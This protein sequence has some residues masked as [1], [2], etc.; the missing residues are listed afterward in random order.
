M[1]IIFRNFSA[2]LFALAA[3][4]F[5]FGYS[6]S[7]STIEVELVDRFQ[8]SL[9]NEVMSAQ[10]PVFSGPFQHTQG[11]GISDRV[12]TGLSTDSHY[13]VRLGE[14]HFV[15]PFGID[16]SF[17]QRLA[18]V[19]ERDGKLHVYAQMRRHVS[20][21]ERAELKG[22]GL[23]LTSYI[24]SYLW[25]A[26]VSDPG[27]AQYLSPEKEK[28]TSLLRLARWVGEIN[29]ADRIQSGLFDPGDKAAK[30]STHYVIVQFH[31]D[32]SLG[33]A[34]RAVAKA[35]GQNMAQ[36]VALHALQ[37]QGPSGTLRR[38]MELDEVKWI[39][40]LP[41]APEDD[42][43]EI[44]AEMNVHIVQGPDYNLD[45]TGVT[46]GQWEAGNADP[47]H[48]DLRGRLTIYEDH[49]DDEDEETQRDVSD[50]ATFVAGI[51]MGN[52]S[53]SVD[54]QGTANQWR[55]VAPNAELMSFQSSTVEVLPGGEHENGT[56]HLN[57]AAMD[58]QYDWALN[59]PNPIALANNSWGTGHQHLLPSWA[60]DS[61]LGGMYDVS[62]EFY[63]HIVEPLHWPSIPVIV[64]A[65]N[66]GPEE[67]QQLWS[68]LRISNS[69]KNPIQV[70]SAFP[71][72]VNP[73]WFVAGTSSRGPT[74]DGR[75]KPDVVAPGDQ[76]HGD[77]GVTST[78]PY[79]YVD[80]IDRNCAPG[81][82]TDSSTGSDTRAP[83][84]YGDDYCYPY[85][86]GSGTSAAAAATSGVVALLLQE[87]RQT[88]RQDPIPSTV[89]AILIHTADDVLKGDGLPYRTDY[90][91]PD[92][93]SG[94]GHINAE[95]T[96]AQLARPETIRETTIYSRYAEQVYQ[97]EITEA[98]SGLKVTL[99]W[100]DVPASPGDDAEDI[101]KND[102]D[103]L[104]INPAGERFYPPWELDPED[105][106]VP[107]VRAAYASEAAAS[108]HRDNVNVVEQVVVDSPEPGF[109]T[110]KVKAPDLPFPGQRY[111]IV[112]SRDVLGPLLVDPPPDVPV[113]PERFFQDAINLLDCASC[114]ACFG[115]ACDPRV[116][117]GYDVFWILELKPDSATDPA[118]VSFRYSQLGLKHRD[119]PLKAAAPLDGW[120]NKSM[121]VASAPYADS[122]HADAGAIFFFDR[123]GK[124]I[125]RITGVVRGERLGSDMD[126]RGNEVVVAST[127]RILR[128]DRGEVVF[129]MD[130][131]LSTA[132]QRDVQVAFTQDIDGD[133]KPEILLGLPYTD[134][135][136][137]SEAGQ[138]RVLG[139]REGEILHVM[140]GQKA[141][142]HL[143]LVLQAI[144]LK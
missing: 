91:G 2:F 126:V 131:E 89:K 18:Q 136:K 47:E 57:V 106:A 142:Q 64:S 39:D 29:P 104:L 99:A 122:K 13:A 65:G 55:G 80:E 19:L 138:I 38:L 102:L 88:H 5:V 46:I 25:R 95:A 134:A 111:S 113:P 53:L 61:P 110:L 54:A 15:P 43:D 82:F 22:L 127:L 9:T 135:G 137:L 114:P 105:P 50:H 27:V 130:L 98:D 68:T 79:L 76:R 85:D 87:W 56:K 128:L 97:V 34:A 41:P 31:E 28:K 6:I 81:T 78:R 32:V 103:L 3:Q 139:S 67:S 121:Y 11:Y 71:P 44:R 14:K 144:A 23:N 92:Y 45:G 40:R 86:V 35:G 108:S 51:M 1:K 10:T 112:A 143:G 101:L 73:N 21:E 69:G 118:M 48:A 20:P 129:D 62:C 7:A 52:G 37:L 96:I 141:G 93:A 115:K 107:A 70:G 49:D 60:D 74:A 66:E 36:V 12:G 72:T 117:V 109:W 17:S 90:V 116:N 124:K 58:K 16:P 140:H 133:R 125:A 100:D 94:Y 84:T 33:D 8:D 63:D 132:E 30:D 120:D 24:G 4:V 119:G 42:N 75:L 83:N 77:E 26:T 59:A 123:S